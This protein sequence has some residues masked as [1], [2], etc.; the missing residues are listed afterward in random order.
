MKNISA[1]ILTTIVFS[2]SALACTKNEAQSQK[3]IWSE[4]T[5]KAGFPQGYNYPVYV[6]ES[7]NL[8]ALNQGGWLSKDGVNWTKT[9]L[10]ESGLNSAYQ[11]YVQFKGAIY[12]LGAMRRNYLGFTI[13]KVILRTTDGKAWETVAEKSNLPDRIFYGAVVFK[14]KIWLVGGYD[15]KDYHNDVW[16]SVDGVN[17]KQV[18][19]KTNWSPRNTS[20][21]VFKNKML[22]LG[23]GAIDGDQEIN[24][25]SGDEFWVS[26]DGVNWTQTAA[27]PKKKRGGTPI[28]FDNKLWFICSNLG[29]GFDSVVLF[30]EDGENFQE[31]NAPWSPRGGAVVWIWNDK[32]YM[33]GGKY[34]FTKNGEI[35][36]VYSSD[37]WAMEKSIKN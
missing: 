14:D 24:P 21:I 35:T 20:V 25:N 31:M 8:L 13:S 12:A 28:V 29:I 19:G 34:S 11:K 7:G 1:I 30:S 17:W 36:F 6:L 9:D 23:G 27:N 26:G 4:I 32:L 10:P 22:L 5:P 15:G 16:N 37:V 33:T 18:V 3:Y 2:F